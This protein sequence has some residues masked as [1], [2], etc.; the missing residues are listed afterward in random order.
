MEPSKKESLKMMSLNI[1]QSI[2]KLN[3]Y[4]EKKQ[5]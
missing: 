5:L 4:F 3:S 1:N 2:L